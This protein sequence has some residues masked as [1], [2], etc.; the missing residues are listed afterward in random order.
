MRGV[1]SLLLVLAVGV[2]AFS[3]MTEEGKQMEED[4]D[5][6]IG[7]LEEQK[8]AHHLFTD[9]QGDQFL[10]VPKFGARILAVSVGGE[11]LFWTHPDV[12]KGQGGVRTWISPEGGA[13]G[14]LFRPDWRGTRDFSMMDPGQY[15]VVE[16]EKD[17]RLVLQ[18]SFRTT[19]NDNKEEYDLTITREMGPL[20]DPLIGEKEFKELT[21]DFLGIDFVHR[22][23][24]NSDVGLERILALWCLI[25]VPPKGT[26]IV[27][28]HEVKDTAWRGNYF[29]PIPEEYVRANADSFSFYV[30]GSRRYKVG[31]RPE[32]ARGIICY[33]S[34]ARSGSY[35]MVSMVFPV[36][37][38]ARYVDRPKTEQE[39]NGD[40]IQ[41]Y[42]HLEE[43]PLAFG[44]MECHSWGLDLRPRGEKGFPVKIYL[45]KAPLDVLEKIG[46]KLVCSRFDKAHL[47]IQE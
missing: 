26:M 31:I 33:L 5:F 13:K 6:I 29:E 20:E 9:E 41:I 8:I 25:Q 2:G 1:V 46:E 45:Y 27:P 44:E 4:M 30:H 34:R 16:F 40:A 11:N 12:L 39:S 36:M 22:L 14:F 37:P 15:R 10:V 24:N 38:E 28:V 32:S 17:E 43:G 23:R 7:V 3:S 42:S 21:Y 18:N 19:S 47:F 35:F